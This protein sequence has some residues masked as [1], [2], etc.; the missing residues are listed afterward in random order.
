MPVPPYILAS[1]SPRRRELIRLIGIEFT[2]IPAD[3]DETQL[4]AEAPRTHVC[5]LA[6]AKAEAISRNYPTSFVLAADTIVVDGDEILGKPESQAHALAI[7]QQ[8][9]ARTH[10]VFTALALRHNHNRL[11]LSEL[12]QSLVPMRAYTDEEIS[13]YIATRDP[14]DKAGAYAIQHAGFHPAERFSGCYASVMG[15]PLCHLARMLRRAGVAAAADIAQSCQSA[16]Q[17]T[18]PVFQRVLAGEDAG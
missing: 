10:V 8:L 9:R 11:A 2:P 7:L 12:C 18:C 1:N 13:A 17:Y 6:D 15:L 5:R 4:P 14:L 3:I 16:L